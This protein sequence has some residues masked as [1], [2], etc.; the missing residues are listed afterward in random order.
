MVSKNFLPTKVE[1]PSFICSILQN[2]ETFRSIMMIVYDD[3]S[4]VFL[5]V[6]LD[7]YH[8]DRF[9]HVSYLNINVI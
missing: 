6:W 5:R 3:P 2:T 1:T 9:Y 8:V 4:I 7:F